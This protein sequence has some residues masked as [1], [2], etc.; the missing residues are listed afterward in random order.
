M[1]MLRHEDQLK[2]SF[3]T[4]NAGCGADLFSDGIRKGVVTSVG[5]SNH[6]SMCGRSVMNVC[7]G[8]SRCFVGGGMETVWTPPA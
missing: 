5:V 2:E 8:L 3:D 7:I 1:R 4:T 6:S